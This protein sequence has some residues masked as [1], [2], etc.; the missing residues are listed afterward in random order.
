MK[1]LGVTTGIL[2]DKIA[3]KQRWGLE[4]KEGPSALDVLERL[5]DRVAKGEV[6]LKLEV[7]R[8]D[9]S[10]EAVDVTPSE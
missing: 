7:T 4:P 2:L 10:E 3:K 6:E 8:R 9:A 5:A 1:E